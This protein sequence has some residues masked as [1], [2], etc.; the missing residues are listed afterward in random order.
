MLITIGALARASGLTP[1]AL[2]F[3][4]DC[5]LLVPAE[6]DPVTGYRYYTEPQRERAVL[7]RKLR[8]IDIPL[9]TVTRILDGETD[10]LDTHVRELHRRARAAA[11][12]AGTIKQL[13]ARTL[14]ARTLAEAVEQV[15]PAAA[16]GGET[17]VLRGVF[18]ELAADAITLTA[19]DRYRLA[20]RTLTARPAGTGAATVG[21]ADIERARTWLRA[22]GEVSLTID[23]DGLLLTAVEDQYRCRTMDE[24]FPDYRLLLSGLEP[25]RK[26]VVEKRAE[27]LAAIEKA[28]AAR[29]HLD[30][31]GLT[32]ERA[33]LRAAVVTAVGPDLLL[34]VSTPDQPVVVR[35]ATDGDFTT[36]AMP[37]AGPHD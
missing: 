32:F 35:S 19:T 27:L 10:L 15:L 25:A 3:Y 33:T 16:I 31:I 29:F 13:L 24:Q 14:P 36:L 17:P 23:D 6:V 4:G 21:R 28:P 11:A 9:E 7:I 20:T 34:E 12:A 18:V 1:S 37:A 26:R 8:E 5:G 2:R 22:H 30:S